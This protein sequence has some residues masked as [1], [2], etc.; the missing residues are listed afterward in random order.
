MT[1]GKIDVAG[2]SGGPGGSIK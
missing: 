1:C 2:G